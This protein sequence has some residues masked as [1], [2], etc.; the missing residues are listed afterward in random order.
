MLLLNTVGL[1]QITSRF[2][3]KVRGGFDLIQ[4]TKSVSNVRTFI[5]DERFLLR[6]QVLRW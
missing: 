2:L 1:S 5:P 4:Y 3:W 6:L